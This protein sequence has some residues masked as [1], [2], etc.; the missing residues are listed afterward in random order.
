MLYYFFRATSGNKEVKYSGIYRHKGDM[1]TLFPDV[2]KFIKE[3]YKN[4]GTPFI[5]NLTFVGAK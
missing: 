5:E 4:S 3:V 2:V 1:D